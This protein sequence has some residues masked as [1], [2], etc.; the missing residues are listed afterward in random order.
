MNKAGHCLV[1]TAVLLSSSSLACACGTER[2]LVRVAADQN[3]VQIEEFPRTAGI[4]ELDAFAAPKIP[5]A[6]PS[7]RFA[8]AEFIA[9]TISGTLLAIDRTTDGDD[10]LIIADPDQPQATIVAVAPDPACAAGSRYAANIAAV[11]DALAR[12]FGNFS[13][14]TPNLPVTATGIAFFSSRRGQAGMAANGI[15]L[16]PLIGIAF[17]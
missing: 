5:D 16:Q 14:L 13:R 15:E 7:A 8:P 3:A 9:Y 12:K 11:R 17:P 2:P 10:R 1:A 6:R 4:P